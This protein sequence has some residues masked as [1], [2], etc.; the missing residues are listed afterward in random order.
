[1]NANYHYMLL[2][3]QRT[4]FT[5]V[6]YLHYN[7]NYTTAGGVNRGAEGTIYPWLTKA[8]NFYQGSP[9]YRQV[10]VLGA[11]SRNVCTYDTNPSGYKLTITTKY[12]GSAKTDSTVASVA[13]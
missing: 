4:S 7:L 8:T 6:E 5:N 3:M 1:M 11:C 10:V 12:F 9:F 13:Q 2:D